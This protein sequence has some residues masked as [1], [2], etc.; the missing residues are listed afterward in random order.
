MPKEHLNKLR[1]EHIKGIRKS[2]IYNCSCEQWLKGCEEELQDLEKKFPTEKD[3]H[4]DLYK[5]EYAMYKKHNSKEYFEKIRGKYVKDL[6]I[7]LNPNSTRKQLLGVFSRHDLS[8]DKDLKNGTY[9]LSSLGWYD[10]Y[11]VIGKPYPCAIHHNAEEAIEWLEVFDNGNNIC[12]DMAW[13]MCEELKII[14][15][16]FFKEFPNGTIHYG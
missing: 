2:Y 6:E 3:K 13:G 5:M 9:N 15:N 12:T 11:R 14:I 7:L 8:F 16:E 1:K 10:N 4:D